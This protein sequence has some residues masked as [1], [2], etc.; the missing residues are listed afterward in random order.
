MVLLQQ[1]G[2][3]R[4]SA[5]GMW[6]Y[7]FVLCWGSVVPEVALHLFCVPWYWGTTAFGQ[8]RYGGACRLEVPGWCAVG[9]G[10]EDVLNCRSCVYF[11]QLRDCSGLNLFLVLIWNEDCCRPSCL[12]FCLVWSTEL[13]L[14]S[15]WLLCVPPGLTF[16]NSTFCPH[17]VF[18]CFVWSSEQTA[19]ISLHSI[20]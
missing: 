12:I 1:T 7:L 11:H 19:I 5:L 2:H 16:S 9:C 18:M 20:N 3:C 15:Q 4:R 17:S 14:C 6:D 10:N 8:L 13:M